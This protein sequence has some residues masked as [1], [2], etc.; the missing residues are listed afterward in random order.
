MPSY[1]Q[2]LRDPRWQ[3]KRLEILNRDDWRCQICAQIDKPLNVHHLFY[4]KG[5]APWQYLDSAFTTLCDECHVHLEDIDAPVTELVDR[6]EWLIDAAMGST[7]EDGIEYLAHVFE[8]LQDCKLDS[9]DFLQRAL[10]VLDP[11]PKVQKCQA[12]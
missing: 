6:W 9:A 10:N 7:T 11:Q 5:R 3:R 8:S 4:I 2:L 12:A 1:S